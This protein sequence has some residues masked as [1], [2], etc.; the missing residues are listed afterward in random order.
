PSRFSIVEAAGGAPAVTTRRPERAPRRSSSSAFARLIRTVG[1]AQSIV[2][3]SFS[4]SSNTARGSTL[5]RH[6]WVAP[7][8]VTVQTNVH[9]FAWNIGNVQRYRSAHD[10]WR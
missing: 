4:I 6:T 2:T 8:A 10:M 3:R 1:A 9:P 5:G 7:A